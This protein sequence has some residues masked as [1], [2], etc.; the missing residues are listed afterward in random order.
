MAFVAATARAWLLTIVRNSCS[1]WLEQN[2]RQEPTTAFDE[3]IHS[4]EEHSQSPEAL[5]LESA[6]A[7]LVRDALEELP[8][9]FREA[10]VLRELEGMSYKEIAG[11]CAI[12]VGTVMSRLA[13]ARQRLE[14]YFTGSLEQGAL[15]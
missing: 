8:P 6:D 1:T 12:P 15:P 5:V 11:L 3:E 14:R 2:R 4:A 10:I 9:E 7:R 13:R